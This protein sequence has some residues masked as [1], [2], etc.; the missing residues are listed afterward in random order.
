MYIRYS[1]NIHN[2]ENFFS[3]IKSG[4]KNSSIILTK[5]SGNVIMEFLD[6]DS[7]DFI[8]NEIWLEIEKGS[9]LYDIDSKINLY[10]D[11]KTYNI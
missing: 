1:G 8:L 4:I 9:K 11:A 10:Y 7:R 2:I 6:T 5:E 3:V